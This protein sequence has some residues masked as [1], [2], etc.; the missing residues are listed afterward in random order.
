VFW[1]LPAL[2]DAP[3]L[4]AVVFCAT[5]IAVEELVAVTS[6]C[7]V[8]ELVPIPTL[9]DESTITL[10]LPSPSDSTMLLLEVRMSKPPWLP[11]YVPTIV[12]LEPEVTRPPEPLPKNELLTA[13]V[14]LY[15][16]LPPT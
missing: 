4:V 6:N 9:P 3:P 2:N 13:V 12:F 10:G 16:A 14:A 11:L 8:G 7:C 1:G 15:A 5:I